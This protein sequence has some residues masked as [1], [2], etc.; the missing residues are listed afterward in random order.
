VILDF[1]LKKGLRGLVKQ[2]T[3]DIAL[4]FDVVIVAVHTI[5]FLVKTQ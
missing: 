4:P 5:P 1:H 3:N 2:K